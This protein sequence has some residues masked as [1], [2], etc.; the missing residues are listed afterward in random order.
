MRKAKD[1]MT[2]SVITVRPETPVN[3]LAKILIE[4]GINGVPVVD[5]QGNL[6][7][8]VTQADLIDQTKK[9]HIPTVIGLLDSVIFLESPKKFE[10]ELKKMAGNTAWDICT[11]KVVTTEE[12]TPVEEVASLMVEKH[13]DTIPVVRQGRL[14]GIIGRVDVVKSLIA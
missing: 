4:H 2:K 9:L 3:E 5:E 12:E 11:Q 6:K 7:A 8:I 14:V 1:I 10:M 13:L